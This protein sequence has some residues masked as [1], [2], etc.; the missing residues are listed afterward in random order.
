MFTPKLFSTLKNYSLSQFR[1]DC[2][3]GVIVGIIA[4]PLAV[5][6]AIAS[7][8]SPDRGLIT[9]VIAGFLI[10]ALGGS[11]VQIGGP[12]GAFV[13][14][15][16]SIVQRHGMDGLMVATIMGGIILVAMGCARFGLAIKYI[17]HP[18]IIGFTSGIA[19]II[20]SSQVK[21]FFGLS[22]DSLPAE[23]VAKWVQII[24]H[25]STINYYALFIGA[26]T[27]F[28]ILFWQKYIK[29]IPGSFVAL[30]LMT[31]MARIFHWPVETIG[32]KF[33]A[34][35]HSIFTLRLPHV[36][37]EM[38]G[39]LM[40]AAFTIAILA[41]I[42][43]LLSA[44]VADGMINGKHRSNMEL[45]AQG[46]ANIITPL[47]GGMPATGA[48]AR[49]AANVHNGGRTPVSGIVHALT[50][51]LI[52]VFFGAWAVL[53]PMPCLAGILLIVAY[54][55]SE[56]H[57]FCMIFKSPRSDRVVLLVT[58]LLTV[59]FDLS[60]AIQISMVMAAFLFIHRLSQAVNMN[61]IMNEFSDEEEKE[62]ALINKKIIPAGVDIFE[63]QG[64]L[65]FGM[66]ST[67][68]EAIKNIEKKP[69]VRILRMRFVQIVD[70]TAIN[71]L[72]NIHRELKKEGVVLIL[73]G[74]QPKVF[75]AL[76]KC[77]FIDEI[78]AGNVCK[79]IDS[80]LN[81]AKE[82]LPVLKAEKQ[83]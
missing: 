64:P 31:V 4:L 57:S 80:A 20:F 49:T 70:S 78:G 39:A 26:G 62:G 15:V 71:A 41:G 28:I 65:F 82:F 3:S 66:V 63:I 72:C 13:V 50:L 8:V 67:F 30:V 40:P 19:L 38:I 27:V 29:K 1:S 45:V 59:F 23:F 5:A 53:V 76:R 79:E 51:L 18:V 48:I 73:S 56:W 25:F 17:P 77:G 54:R 46:V 32:S 44:A 11:R 10:S 55:M 16:Y 52:M 61:V 9:A 36:N 34:M 33:G 58:F 22:I 83:A 68:L 7:G 14:I 42:E 69:R 43:S 35:P 37:F 81:R 6:F 47:F 75:S 12:T 2:I 60:L 21:D 74:V 24:E